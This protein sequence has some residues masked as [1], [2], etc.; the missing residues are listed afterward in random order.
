M[1]GEQLEFNPFKIYFHISSWN[2]CIPLFQTWLSSIFYE[3]KS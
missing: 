1:S 2:S 3:K